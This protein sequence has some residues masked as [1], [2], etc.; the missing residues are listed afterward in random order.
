MAKITAPNKGYNGI[1]AGV[2]FTNGQAYCSDTWVNKWFA[3]HGYIVE[4]DNNGSVPVDAEEQPGSD[5]SGNT[6]RN[7]DP[8]IKPKGRKGK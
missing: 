6:D 1:S 8:E 2:K 7:E 5:G 3:E 4:E